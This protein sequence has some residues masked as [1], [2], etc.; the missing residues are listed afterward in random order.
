M[1]VASK[2]DYMGNGLLTCDA[3][4][5]R[6]SCLASVFMTS[7]EIN[8]EM[9]GSSGLA[10]QPKLLL[11]DEPA[12]SVQPGWRGCRIPPGLHVQYFRPFVNYI[13]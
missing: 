6:V 8:F 3:S 12:R 4:F 9:R 7:V 10:V 2:I 13:S 5:C 11:F 1:S